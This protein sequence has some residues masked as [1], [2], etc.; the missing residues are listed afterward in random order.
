MKGMNSF[1]KS[2]H[3]TRQEAAMVFVLVILLAALMFSVGL[4]VGMGYFGTHGPIAAHGESN[5]HEH[6]RSPASAEAE[7]HH[8]ETPKAAEAGAGLKKSFQ[9]SKQKALTEAIVAMQANDT[10]KSILD[11]VAHKQTHKEWDR[12]PASSEA[13]QAEQAA[14]NDLKE[15]EDRRKRAGPPAKVQG[16]FERSPDSVKDFDPVPGNYTLQLASF[17]TSEEAAAMV[18]QLRRAGFLDAYTQAVSFKNGETWHRVAVGSY[19]NPVYARQMGDRIRRRG[20]SKDF[21]VRKVAD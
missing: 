7:K 2:L 5:P 16:L 20:L 8:V 14:L 1:Q 4:W 10:P 12:Q 17:A 15:R 21:I 6:D 3:L 9:E 19:P 13:D 11:V 18:K